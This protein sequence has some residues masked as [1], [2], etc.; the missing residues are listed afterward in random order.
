MISFVLCVIYP[1][2]GHRKCSRSPAAA[3][4]GSV[5]HSEGGAWTTVQDPQKDSSIVIKG[6]EVLHELTSVALAFKDFM[7]DC[8]ARCSS[9]LQ[10]TAAL[11]QIT[12][13]V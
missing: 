4:H 8:K 2:A 3:Y 9:T 1:F 6:V 11:S 12:F 10:C 5:C 7:A 13:V